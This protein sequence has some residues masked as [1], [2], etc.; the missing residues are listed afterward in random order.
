MMTGFGGPLVIKWTGSRNTLLTPQ[1]LLQRS[2]RCLH[3]QREPGKSSLVSENAS[4]AAGVNYTK[5]PFQPVRL[6]EPVKVVCQLLVSIP[7]A[8]FTLGCSGNLQKSVTLF[9]GSQF[10]AAIAT[11]VW[12]VHHRDEESSYCY[13]RRGQER[14]MACRLQRKGEAY[15]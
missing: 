4:A 14:E 11:R 13:H 2:H 5:L 6:N 7:N 8:R 15:T 10:Q 12:K 9:S 3:L 1:S